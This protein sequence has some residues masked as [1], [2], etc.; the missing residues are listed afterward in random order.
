MIRR[1]TYLVIVFL[2]VA[3]I[4]ALVDPIDGELYAIKCFFI[5][6]SVFWL[7]SLLEDFIIRDNATEPSMP[8]AI[9]AICHILGV[10]ACLFLWQFTGGW[11]PPYPLVFIALIYVFS[12][13]VYVFTPKVR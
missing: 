1:S 10:V 11:G 4:L 5:C 12:A 13:I 6:G 8:F 3:G 9:L 7:A 2:I